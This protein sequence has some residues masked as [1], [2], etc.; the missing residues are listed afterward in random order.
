[1]RLLAGKVD[2][3]ELGDRIVA[4]LE[5]HFVVELLRASEAH[6]GVD[7]LVAGDVEVADELVEEQAAQALR[8]AAVAREQGTLDDLRQVDQGEDRAVEI[9]EVAPQDVG[10]FRSELL[11]DVDSHAPSTSEQLSCGH[12]R[13]RGGFSTV[14]PR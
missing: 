13:S 3:A 6:R 14:S 11:G 9:G 8:A 7:G 2:A 1:G 4:V 12:R 5:E 10:L